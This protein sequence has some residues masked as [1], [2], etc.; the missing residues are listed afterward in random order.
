MC[1]APCCIQKGKVQGPFGSRF[2]PGV[3]I[4]YSKKSLKEQLSLNALVC[5]RIK[6]KFHSHACFNLLVTEDDVQLTYTQVY[7]KMVV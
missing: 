2:S 5:T 7:E 3:T 4:T 6:T 1:F